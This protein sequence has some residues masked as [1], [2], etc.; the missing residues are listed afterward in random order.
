MRLDMHARAIAYY[1]PQYHPVGVND[2]FWGKGFTEWTNVTKAKP[3]FRGHRQPKLPADLGF[4]DLRV[5]EVRE[6]QAQLAGEY[7]IEGFCYWHYWFG[8][9]RRVLERPFQEVLES[10]RP[11]FPF[12]IGWANES[13][14]GIWHGSPDRVIVEQAYPGRDDYRDHFRALLPAFRD[15]RYIR[16]DGRCLVFIYKPWLLPDARAFVTCWRELADAAGLEGLYFVG[17][18]EDGKILEQGFDA[19]TRRNR[20]GTPAQVPLDP[21]LKMVNSALWRTMHMGFDEVANRLFGWPVRREYAR[22]VM[23]WM[24]E[25][26]GEKELPVILPNWDNT[27]RCGK[28]GTLYEHCSSEWFEKMARAAVKELET[29]PSSERLLWIRSWNEWAEGNY[30][31]PDRETGFDYLRAL[32]RAL[33]TGKDAE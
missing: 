20:G 21:I 27:P 26:P 19:Y 28:N 15:P 14:T 16:V 7:G 12:C 3:L 8:N 31:E 17:N 5:P 11:D 13:W 23:S 32:Q 24:Q 25:G 29:R 1:L 30:L 2:D 10:G 33:S 18:S 22:Y 6:Q 9:G 4:Y